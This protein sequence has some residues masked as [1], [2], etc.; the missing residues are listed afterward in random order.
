MY[1]QIII[2]GLLLGGLYSCI[3]A[4]FSLVWGVLN[5]INILHGSLI[6]LGA[7][8]AYFA[9]A[10]FGLNPFFTAVPIGFVVFVLG[11]VL[12]RTVINKVVGKPVLITLSLTF[13]LD[14]I[15]NDGMISLFRADYR[16]VIF[17]PPLPV[18]ELGSVL[19][20]ADR[21]IATLI[22]LACVLVIW[23]LMRTTRLG[24]AIIAVRSD[25][26]TA[27]L[28]GIRVRDVYAMSF[29]IA[30]G[31]AG[32]AGALLAAIFPISPLMAGGYMGK[33]FAIC[34]FG[35]LGNLPGAI[36]GG[37]ALGLIESLASA[38]F[39]PQHT[40]TVSFCL[41]IALLYFRPNGMFGKKGF[42]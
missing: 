27:P 17:D 20:P 40:V 5:I 23:L 29:A 36:A 7:Y 34:V 18:L 41:L 4:G 39:G 6:V 42:E 35:G 13:G 30:A 26:A 3:A 32:I 16:K 1:W 28:M 33:S 31:L 38:W 24:R 8:I 21:L 2:N 15:L 22:S 11:Y 19:I 14:L 12:Q 9:H 25:I 37:M 10:A